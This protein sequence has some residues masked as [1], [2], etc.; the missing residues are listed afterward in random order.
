MNPTISGRGLALGAVVLAAAASVLAG[1]ASSGSGIEPGERLSVYVSM[2][3]RGQQAPAGRDV[4]DGARM[5]LADARGRVGELRIRAVYM[6]DTAGRGE[7]AR[8]SPATAA[9]NARRASE[10]SAAIAYIGDFESGATRFSLPI[11]N[12][13]HILQVSP[14]SAA[15]DLAQ[16]FLG[17]GDQVPEEVQPTGERTFGRVIPSDEAQAGAAAAWAKKLGVRGVNVF[18]DSSSFGKTVAT[19]FSDEGRAL[20]L[21]PQR[22][23]FPK[24]RDRSCGVSASLSRADSYYA[25]AAVP[26]ASQVSCALAPSAR[27]RVI[28]T[29]AM[30]QA[31]AIKAISSRASML[32]TAAAQDPEQ[33]PPAG[34]RFVRDF[35]ARY[36]REPGPYA[37]YGYEAM[38]VVLDAIARAGESGDQRDAVV[39]AFLETAG[40]ESI[41]GTYSID[42]AGNT[43]LNRLSGYRVAGRR[44]VFTTPLRAP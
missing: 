44:P 1:C 26:S 43:T 37:A 3:L 17:A 12:E 29:D 33:L 6:D 20:G 39:D 28:G 22:T 23:G 25:G 19:A 41:L 31:A 38:A 27:S 8:W 34:Q 9:A 40:R 42:E 18:A 11:T 24:P 10:D 4:A 16:P 5:A 35:R 14:A 15:V 7:R 36:D 32:I 21:L 2:P 13:A 30:L